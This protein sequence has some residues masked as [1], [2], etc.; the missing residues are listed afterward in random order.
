M[1]G[2]AG[3][4]GM[5]GMGGAHGF[6]WVSPT[7]ETYLFPQQGVKVQPHPEQRGEAK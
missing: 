6:Y 3:M 4:Q 5:S 2:M 1:S 7:G